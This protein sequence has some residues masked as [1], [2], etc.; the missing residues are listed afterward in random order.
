MST[1]CSLKVTTIYY[2]LFVIYLWSLNGLLIQYKLISYFPT[3]ILISVYTILL[4]SSK[5][6]WVVCFLPEDGWFLPPCLGSLSIA[7]EGESAHSE[8]QVKRGMLTKSIP[9]IMFSKVAMM[10]WIW[11]LPTDQ[12]VMGSIHTVRVFKISPKY[13]L[14]YWNVTDST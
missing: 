9:K 10:W 1:L 6:S 4:L 14:R 5:F 2:L 12:E 8:K 7:L 11:S 13:N 3:D